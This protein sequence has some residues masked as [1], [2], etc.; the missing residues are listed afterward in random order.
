[1]WAV[2]VVGKRKIVQKR[3]LLRCQ[4]VEKRQRQRFTMDSVHFQGF[5]RVTDSLTPFQDSSEL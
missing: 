3:E 4:V 2:G 5:L 1:M